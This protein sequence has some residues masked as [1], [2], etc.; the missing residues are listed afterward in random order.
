MNQGKTIEYIEQGR[1]VCT[2][3]LQDKGNRLHLLTPSNR[4]INLASK[5]ILL[6]SG[7]S[8]DTLSSREKLLNSLKQTDKLRNR[9]KSEVRVNELWELINEEN[10]SFDYKYLAHL[11]FGETATGDH[12]SAL[13]RALFEDKFYFRMREGR[14]IPNSKERVEQIAKKYEEDALREKTLGAGSTWLRNILQNRATQEPPNKKDIV[15]LLIS[16]ALYEKEAPDFMYGK[17]LLSRAG[18]SDIRQ[19]GD[20]LIRLGIW[21]EDENL[22]LL[23]SGIR[24]FFNEELINESKNLAGIETEANGREDLRDLPTITIDGPLTRDFDDALSIEIDHHTIQLGI[25]ITDVAGFI[26]KNSPLDREACLRA[27]SLYLSRRQIPMLPPGLSEDTL[28]LKQGHDRPAISLVSS[29]DMSG[30][31]LDYRFTPSLIRVQKQLTYDQVN[32]LYKHEDPLE[33]MHRLSQ[34]MLQRR[35]EQGALILSSPEVSI[36]VDSDSSVSLNKIDQD[37]PS[38]AIVAEFMIFYNWMA[39]RFCRD[40]HIPI[41]Y[42]SQGEP[43]ERLLSDDKDYL[44][45]LFK[46]RRKLSRLIIDAEPKHHAGLGR[47][48]YTNLS[49]PIRRYMDLVAQRQIRNF[50]FHDTPVYNKEELDKIRISVEPI[51]KDLVRIKRNRVQYWTKKYFFQNPGEKISALVLDIMKDRYRI[52]LTDF[53]LVEYLRKQNDLK[54]NEGERITVKIKQ[55]DPWNDKLVLEYVDK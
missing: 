51:L 4:E 35:I 13:V 15:E 46:Q 29:F 2:I 31:L 37:T 19:A 32:E 38:R 30:N 24:I 34:S 44:Y 14:F 3:C 33:Q 41:L 55:S 17:E 8:I 16:I 36:S 43:V 28:S 52:L 27:S 50:L 26:P 25:H 10:D 1:I 53:L 39:A 47:D 5:R 22:D 54:F 45:F 20:L 6:V 23:R 49:S 12:I 21:E 18:I 42:R 40:N 48:V 9:L 11:C 7:S